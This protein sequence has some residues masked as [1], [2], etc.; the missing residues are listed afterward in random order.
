MNAEMEYYLLFFVLV[1]VGGVCAYFY[2]AINNASN[3]EIDEIAGS[4]DG[5]PDSF[6]KLIITNEKNTAP[7]L[8]AEHFFYSLS[9]SMALVFTSINDTNGRTIEMLD[10]TMIFVAYSVA[11]LLLKTVFSALGHRYS[12]YILSKQWTV[13]SVISNLFR[14]F[15]SLLEQIF[16]LISGRA[17]ENALEELDDLVE[18]AH[19]GGELEHG[20]YRLLKNIMQFSDVLVS[21]VM[22]PRTVVFSL[23]AGLTASAALLAPELQMYSRIPI[24]QGSSLDEGAI[25]YVMSKDIMKAVIQG[26]GECTLCSLS[27][28]LQFIPDNASLDVALESFLEKRQHAFLVVD[29]YGGIDGL[30]TMEDVLET[31]LGAEIV[32]EADRFV[33]LRELAKHRRDRR[34]AGASDQA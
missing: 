16:I 5:D 32:D 1:I 23:S 11:I 10:L 2:S 17:A 26:R 13:A 31:I 21:D 18:T 25:G 6:R 30:I 34:I 9:V 29:E 4:A 7:L 33:D 14:P 8:L 12:K 27:R 20:E 22:T 3:D 24:W 19:D 15:S 28:E